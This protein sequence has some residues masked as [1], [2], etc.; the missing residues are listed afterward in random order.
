MRNYVQRLSKRL[1][2]Q[3]VRRGLL[4]GN[5][6]WLAIGALA[7]L[8]RVLTKPY[9]P[10]VVVERLKAGEGLE[11]R[12]IPTPRRGRSGRRDVSPASGS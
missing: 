11:V 5:D 6:V 4:E 2:R 9:Q 7:L 10:N 3:G 12:H 1:L 8:A